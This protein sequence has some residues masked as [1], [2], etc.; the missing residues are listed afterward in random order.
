M[1]HC[2]TPFHFIQQG[3]AARNKRIRLPLNIY[4]SWLFSHF[5]K[6]NSTLKRQTTID[7]EEKIWISDGS[8]PI[9]GLH[10]LSV[11]MKSD[12]RP[13][14]TA[15]VASRSAIRK[16]FSGHCGSYPNMSLAFRVGR[17]NHRLPIIEGERVKKGQTDCSRRSER[18]R[19]ADTPPTSGYETAA[20]QLEETSGCCRD[21]PFPHK[22]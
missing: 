3:I 9:S 1:S 11:T 14:K 20:A 19:P 17:T 4:A 10:P 12:I 15:T 2:D 7:Y 16:D 5:K 13:V 6:K 8:P 21:R 22:R 18:H